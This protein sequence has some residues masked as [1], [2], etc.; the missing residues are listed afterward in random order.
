MMVQEAPA[1]RLAPQVVVRVKSEGL[2]PVKAMLVIL[3]EPVPLFWSVTAVPA[4]VLPSLVTA[5]ATEVGDRLTV[6]DVP[7]PVSAAV[8]GL[9]GALSVTVS[10]ADLAPEAVGLNV[11]LIAQLAPAATLLPQVFVCEKSAP[12][13]PVNVMLVIVNVAVP[14]LVSVTA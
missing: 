5:N 9:L 3:K 12:L 11:T 8:W 2:V 1:A 14:L 10:V 4:L 6:D 13:A 7:V